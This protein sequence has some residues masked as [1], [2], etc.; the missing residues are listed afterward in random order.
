M[1]DTEKEFL[2]EGKID[3]EP[4]EKEELVVA[5]LNCNSNCYATF[6]TTYNFDSTLLWFPH[7][8][9]VDNLKI[10]KP[11]MLLNLGDQL[12]ESRPTDADKSGTMSSYLDYLYKWYLWYWAYG[13]LT[14]N[15]PSV[16][17]V[18]D[19]DVFQG[20]LWGAGGVKAREYLKNENDYPD[21]YKKTCI[22]CWNADGGGYTM[23]AAFVNMVE[24]T[25]T[26]HLPDPYD[27]T[28]LPYGIK[29]YFTSL[30]YAG[31]SF[32]L[33]E[34]RKFKSSPSIVIPTAKIVNGFSQL[35]KYNTKD[36]DVM[37]AQL[38]GKSQENFID[39]W[40]QDW[41]NV[42]VKIAVSQT[43]LAN[44]STMPSSFKNDDSIQFIGVYGEDSIPKG[45]TFAK[46]MDSDGWPQQ[47]RNTALQGF[48]KGFAFHIGGDQH[49]G[50]LLQ[51][52][53]DTWGD[54]GFSFCV[55]PIANAW[56]RRWFPPYEGKRRDKGSPYYTGD[57]EDGF[58]N[59]IT[60]HAAANPHITMQQP[61]KLYD[62][63][64][65]YGIVKINT[66]KQQIT[67]ECWPRYAA[68]G[69]PNH[70]QFSGWPMT[71]SIENNYTYNAP[72]TIGKIIFEEK[73]PNILVQVYSEP[74]NEI[75]YT[76]KTFAKE[77]Y[78]NVFEK[79][80]YSL[81]ITNLNNG[82]KIT[83]SNLKTVERGKAIVIETKF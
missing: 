25:Q 83:R 30:K 81:V 82:K 11:D 67:V 49:I 39:Q 26:A 24:R 37:G 15:I 69:K 45:Y 48:R 43:E 23:P 12:Y 46:D 2:Y 76:I 66:K 36:F 34:D 73:D 28:I 52:G 38:F 13:D 21:H 10:Q 78:C 18:D 70:E 19:H 55:P 51:H 53:I 9:L 65:G 62:L 61:D 74:T 77:F 7:K 58:G 64:S 56:P 20:N 16:C 63:V 72:Y 5:T 75:V 32:A 29:T 31:V 40:A 41:D 68:P 17:L 59:K 6:N 4:A 54:A 14:R 33:L 57:Y 22:D 80:D 42:S 50:V 27:K 35:E 1:D 47:A 60:I 71:I 8:D 79:G 3:H 44:V